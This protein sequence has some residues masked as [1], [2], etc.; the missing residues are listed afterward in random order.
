MQWLNFHHLLLFT[1]LVREGSLVA[2]GR[3]LRLSHST[4][5]AQI[6]TLEENLG[7]RLVERQGRRLVPTEMGRR[8]LH[9]ADGI[10]GLGQELLEAVRGAAS[11]S[12]LRVGVVDAMPKLMVRRLLEPLLTTEPSIH[13]ICSE[14]SHQGALADLARHDLDVVLSDTPAEAGG[15]VRAYN[16][17]LGTCETSFF[18]ASRYAP[19]RDAFPTSLDGVPMLVQLEGSPLRRALNT[20]FT[21]EHIRPR[22]IGEFEDSALL[23]VMAENGAGIFAA[24]SAVEREICRQFGVVVLGRVPELREH[25]YAISLERRIK[26]SAI[27]RI[28]TTAQAELFASPRQRA[29]RRKRIV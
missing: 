9:Y 27:Q 29:P 2:A 24:P 7:V 3:T 14:D 1:T 17:L 12:R 16:H 22:I 11:A 23:K 15:A 10:F 28:F 20:W 25:F 5:S 21:A 8:V 13:V 18:G 26:D 4:L 6:K 19:L